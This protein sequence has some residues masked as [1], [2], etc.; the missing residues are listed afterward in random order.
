MDQP[1]ISIRPMPGSPRAHS[2]RHVLALLSTASVRETAHA[3]TSATS[4]DTLS[5][6]DAS[7]KAQRMA[8]AYSGLSRTRSSDVQAKTPED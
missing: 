7:T 8:Q 1:L 2:P 5:K 6:L 4:E 3:R